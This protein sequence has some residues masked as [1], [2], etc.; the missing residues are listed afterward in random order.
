MSH[1][2]RVINYLLITS[3][4][5]KRISVFDE[6][7]HLKNRRREIHEQLPCFNSLSEDGILVENNKQRVQ[8]TMMSADDDILL[9]GITKRSQ[10]GPSPKV[11]DFE[12]LEKEFFSGVSL[13]NV[14]LA[15]NSERRVLKLKGFPPLLKEIAEI[16]ECGELS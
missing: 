8:I 5:I 9:R 7:G 4:Q 11:K 14:I 1:L 12:A 13:P 10:A 6:Q 3:P 16:L 2:L 15:F